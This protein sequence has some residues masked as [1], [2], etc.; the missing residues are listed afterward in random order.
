LELIKITHADCVAK[1]V[2]DGG[3]IDK[4]GE[5]EAV[6]LRLQLSQLVRVLATDAPESNFAIVT[7]KLGLNKRQP[8]MV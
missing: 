4:D 1:L 6:R 3:R 8:R 2:S 5:L 7:L